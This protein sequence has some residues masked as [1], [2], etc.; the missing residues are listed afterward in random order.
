MSRIKAISASNASLHRAVTTGV[1]VVS[2]LAADRA[3]S[4]VRVEAGTPQS[5]AL[6]SATANQS[7]AIASCPSR[8]AESQSV[9]FDILVHSA[10]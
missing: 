1:R 4:S 6:G 7:R 5:P 8:L 10:I 9:V 2:F 3:P